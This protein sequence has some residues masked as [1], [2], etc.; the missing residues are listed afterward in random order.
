MSAQGQRH[1][2]R[3]ARAVRAVAVTGTSAALLAAPLLGAA[4]ASAA[5]SSGGTTR[6]ITG[7]GYPNNLDGWIRASLEVMR[8]HG[9]PGTY[10]GIHRNIMRE[11]SGN[12]RAINLW[13]SNAAKGTPSKG[14]LQ[15]IEPT[16]R[17]YHV[18]GTSYDIYDP[19]AN[20]TAAC[21]YAAKRYGSID[22]V[23][24]PY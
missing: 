19:V 11:S 23:N 14:L 21:N 13:D 16:F 20:I 15:V 8:K 10:N 6:T 7:A 2:S 3:L 12:P 1:R 4:G 17:A 24:G 5:P 9:I 22:N 18:P